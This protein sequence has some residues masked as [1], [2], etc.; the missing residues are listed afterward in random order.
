MSEKEEKIITYKGY[1]EFSIDVNNLDSDFMDAHDIEP[2]DIYGSGSKGYLYKV[3]TN[4]YKIYNTDGE[5][6]DVLKECIINECTSWL[7]DLD[8]GI[9]LGLST[10]VENG[11]EAW[12]K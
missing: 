6:I 7:N 3:N 11:V 2:N 1:V 10:V 9:E 8:I 5:F 4:G 12:T